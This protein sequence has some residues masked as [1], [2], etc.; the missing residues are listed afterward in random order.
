MRRGRRGRL[1][2]IESDVSMRTKTGRM[3]DILEP[4]L[5][6]SK[7]SFTTATIHSRSNIRPGLP[8]DPYR[9]DAEYEG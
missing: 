8:A 2:R 1:Y 5:V 4:R 7:R 6:C 3:E 9:M